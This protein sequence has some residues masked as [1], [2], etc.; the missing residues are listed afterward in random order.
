MYGQAVGLLRQGQRAAAEALCRQIIE[1]E[2]DHVDA[3]HAL[4]ILSLQKGDA[5]AGLRLV[6]RSLEINPSQAHV[7]CSLGNALRDLGR[8]EEALASY[9]SAL[10]LAP[11]FAGALFNRGNVLLEMGRAQEA[12]ASFDQALRLEPE[13]AETHLN[14]GNALLA[15]DRKQEALES[16]QHV[17]AH[18]ADLDLALENCVQVLQQLGRDP[19]ALALVDRLAALRPGDPEVT[20]LRGTLLV[21]CGRL[22]QGVK[23]LNTALLRLPKSVTA[24]H[25]RAAAFLA[26]KQFDRAVADCETLLQLEPNLAVAHAARG[27]ALLGLQQPTVALESFERALHGRPDD[28]EVLAGRGLALRALGRY[29]PA[30]AAFEQASVLSPQSADFAYREAVTL[31]HLKRHTEAAAAFARARRLSADYDYALGNELH[32]RLQICDWSAYDELVARTREAVLSGRRAC[33]PGALLSI[34]DQPAA[35]LRCAQTFAT[36]KYAVQ[37][38]PDRSWPQRRH[39]RIRVGYVSADFRE[40][41]VS[42]LMAGVFEQHDRELIDAIGVSLTPPDGSALGERVARS[43]DQFIDVSDANDGDVEELLRELEL[44]IAVDLMGYSARARTALFARRA[45]PVQVNFLG[46]PGTLGASF[47]DYVIAD[48][49]VIPEAQREFYQEQVVYL[50]ECFQPN[51]ARRAMASDPVGRSEH[52]LPEQGLVF[53]CFNSHYKIAPP[54]FDVWMRLLRDLDGSVLWLADGGEAVRANLRREAL[55]RGVSGERLVFA[56]RQPRVAEH[57]ARYRLADLFLDTLPFGAHATASDALWAGVPLLTCCG[58]A[59]AARVAASLLVTLG[60]PEL[61]TNSLA[62][63]EAR[64]RELATD[65]ARL[66]QCRARLGAARSSA[67]LFDTQRYCRHLERAYRMMRQRCERGQGPAHLVVEPISS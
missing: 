56:P 2:P 65:P 18:R 40:H 16:Y 61:V 51:D 50:P 52:G 21:K 35:Q 43:F 41:P 62:D 38:V 58:G 64:A 3:L 63:Y 60:L 53:C 31:R 7:H 19:E 30:L 29:E 67:P 54:V 44:D 23:V 26:L 8:A 33:L 14:R 24:L 32:E 59:F 20:V 47:Y 37:A 15:L 25:A 9:T 46:Y 27:H 45:A 57:L 22:D 42:Q 48:R 66:H 5:A 10:Q 39:Q 49:I 6:Q 12:L 11:K 4:G 55:A 28:A 36:D 13:H 1:R 34:S 17:L